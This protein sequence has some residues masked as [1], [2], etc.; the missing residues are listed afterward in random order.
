MTRRACPY[1]RLPVP[2]RPAG[3]RWPSPDGAIGEGAV[4]IK[5]AAELEGVSPDAIRARIARGTLRAF[6][7]GRRL[8]I[9]VQDLGRYRKPGFS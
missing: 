4:S 7:L 8:V 5:I 6:R 1:S 3:S 9:R 2:R